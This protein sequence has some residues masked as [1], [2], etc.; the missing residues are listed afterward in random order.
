[1]A[2][3]KSKKHDVFID[4]TAMSDVTVLL[5]TFFMFTATFKDPDP[6]ELTPPFSVSV[7]KKADNNSLT[8]LVDT[9]GHVYLNFSEND[10]E[11]KQVVFDKI[12]ADYDLQF[13]TKQKIAFRDQPTIGV[14][15]GQMNEFLNLDDAGQSEAIRK[16]GIPTDSI[17]N[18]LSVWLRHSRDVIGESN[19]QISIKADKSTTYPQVNKVMKTLTDMKLNRYTLITS[20]EGMP[21][22]F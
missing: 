3:V 6:V 12:A 2:K 21:E 17:N 22:G 8:I 16:Y 10:K 5:L 4:M 9:V 20:L 13:N 15:I 18:E 11:V 14:S 1:M 7:K 19:M